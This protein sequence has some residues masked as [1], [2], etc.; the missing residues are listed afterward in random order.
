VTRWLS[1]VCD[2]TMT[3][4][5]YWTRLIKFLEKDAK[6]QHQKLLFKSTTKGHEEPK[7]RYPRDTKP[8]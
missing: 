4:D 2:E 7:E 5:K 6:I 3:D 8:K 1:D